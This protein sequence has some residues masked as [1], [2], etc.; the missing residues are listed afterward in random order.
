MLLICAMIVFEIRRS[1]KGKK[2][3]IRKIP[4]LDALTE[5]IGR[6]TEMGRPVHYSAGIS[7]LT[8]PIMLASLE[9]LSYI[10]GQCARYGTKLIATVAQGDVFA[11]S[12]EVARAA[13]SQEGAPDKFTAD[14]VRFLSSN[15]FV[16]GGG[17]AGIVNREKVATNII[18]GGFADE[19]LFIA[20]S[21]HQAGALQIGGTQ[22][23]YQIP[24]FVAA[25]DFTLLGEEIFAGS[26]YYS[27][28]PAELGAI[29]GQDFAKALAVIMVIV[30]AIFQT[31]KIPWLAQIMQK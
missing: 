2:F 10:A 24:F 1:L 6:A 4:A 30:G 27:Q 18:I 29:S 16:Y 3:R 8:A 11:V 17:I 12:T 22:N 31:L 26:A 5:G 23:R 15:Q 14:T 25:C 9:Y 13:Y 28:D 7:S 20:E 19:A 21:G